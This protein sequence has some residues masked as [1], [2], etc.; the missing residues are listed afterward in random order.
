MPD[1]QNKLKQ[2]LLLMR[3]DRPI[4]SFLLL[5]PTLWALWL[6]GNG[7]PQAS[8]V[9]IFIAGVFVMRSAGCV[10]NDYA[11]RHIDPEVARTCS[12]P[13]AA[14]LVQPRE[15]LMLFAVL[16]GIALLLVLQ[17]NILTIKLSVVAVILAASYPF[18]KRF[19]NLPQVYLGITFGWSIPMA[20]AAQN[21]QLPATVWLLFLANICWTVAYDTIYA[22]VD[23]DDDVKIGVKSTA[24]LFGENDRF[25]IGLLQ[26]ITLALL[27]WVGQIFERGSFYYA[28]L[29][30][31][32]FFFLYQQWLITERDPTRCLQAFLNNSWFGAVVFVGLVLD[33]LP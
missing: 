1:F 6:A 23:R 27:I 8:I 5:W 28:G 26:L 18:V 31:A 14:G 3:A 4:G 33:Y 24:I 25:I 2:Y 16:C 12:R 10:I 15:A 22:M 21:G 29:L 9:L 13:I 19:T 30:M 17:L 11:D 7:Q 20:F 32:S